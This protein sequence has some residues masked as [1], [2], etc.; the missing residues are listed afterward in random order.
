MAFEIDKYI[1]YRIQRAFETY[2]DALLL[3]NRKSLK[4]CVNRLYYSC[5][6]IVTALLIKN[7]IE[8][9]SHNHLLKAILLRKNTVNYILICMI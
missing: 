7:G 9:K 2:S 3:F 1:D 4:S 6:Y 8:A 5:F